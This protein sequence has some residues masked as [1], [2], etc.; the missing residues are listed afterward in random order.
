MT[1]TRFSQQL[2]CKTPSCLC[3]GR[4]FGKSRLLIFMTCERTV[5]NVVTKS[6]CVDQAE[7]TGKQRIQ[8]NFAGTVLDDKRVTGYTCRLSTLDK[9]AHSHDLMGVC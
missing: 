1:A 9:S 5:V 7:K 3:I 6:L 8:T 4:Y 2:C